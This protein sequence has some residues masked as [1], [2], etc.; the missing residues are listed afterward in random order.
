MRQLI[1]VELLKLKRSLA[2]LMV[3]ACPLLVVIL[4]FG[5]AL[6]QT[7]AAK[8]EAKHWEFFW[9]NVLAVWCYFMLPLFVA[10]ITGLLNGIE[11]KNSTWRLMLTQPIGQRQLYFAKL[12]LACLSIVIAQS[13]LMGFSAISV[14]LLNLFGYTSEGAWSQPIFMRLLTLSVACLPIV[15]IHHSLSWVSSNIVVPLAAGVMVTLGIL[16]VG[17]SGLWMYYPWTYSLMAVNGGSPQIQ[18]QALFLSLSSGVMLA[19]V[20]GF[21]L[22]KM[23]LKT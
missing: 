21:A 14:L 11:Y 7:P 4:N 2:L 13:A 9:L 6:K 3:F 17:S 23:Q 15:V 20:L 5:I 10:L 22:G 1:L 19:V 8:F 18:Q 16:Q 12:I